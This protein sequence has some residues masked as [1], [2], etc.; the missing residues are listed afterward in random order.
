MKYRSHQQRASKKSES[1]L[2]RVFNDWIV[3]RLGDDFGIDFDVRV[4]EYM[5]DMKKQKVETFAFFLQLKS[6]NDKC[7]G[8]YS[9]KLSMSDLIFFYEQSLPVV[10]IKYYEKCDSFYYEI[11]QTYVWDILNEEDPNWRLKKYK[12][13]PLTKKF[14][15]L[16]VLK[17]EL[18]ETSKRIA[19]NT[20]F[21]MRLGD[22]IKF[23]ES[24]KH[25]QKYLLEYKSLSMNVAFDA[26]KNG[27]FENAIST[28]EEIAN[29]PNTDE[30]K[31]NAILNIIQQLNPKNPNNHYK[32]IKL[33]NEGEELA[34]RLNAYNFVHI[35]RI[36]R[37]R[38]YLIINI[39]KLSQL[40]YSRKVNADNK[41]SF[42]SFYQI[43]IQSNIQN[44][45]KNRQDITTNINK[46]LVDIINSK[47]REAY[48]I[49]LLEI[50]DAIT[51]QII[52]FGQSNKEFIDKEEELRSPIADELTRML[53][54]CD[55]DDLLQFGY[56]LL[57]QYYYYIKKPGRALDYI[58]RAIDLL[59]KLG[60]TSYLK[61]YENFLNRIK[62]V[63]DPHIN[64]TINPDKTTLGELKQYYTMQLNSL[65]IYINHPDQITR[66]YIIPALNDIDPTN[67]LKY[68][69]YLRVDYLFMSPLGKSIGL[70]SLGPKV[71]WCLHSGG[72][73]GLRF[74]LL[75]DSFVSTYCNNCKIKQ[76]RDDG[77]SCTMTDLFKISNDKEFLAFKESIKKQYK[78]KIL[79]VDINRSVKSAILR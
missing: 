19:R 36:L 33:S 67:Y 31:L 74:D 57:S 65:G 21:N 7:K 37:E 24:Q 43:F 14:E 76:K 61:D 35:F 52:S 54:I 77:W 56:Y 13:I 39:I 38:T 50:I 72:I 1:E 40:F 48:T 71:I 60:Y 29:A 58:N 6:N 25:R 28:F 17:N 26:V 9:E 11:I 69:K 64:I 47:D 46:I 32:I 68:C 49:A 62:T 42:G 55:N 2:L 8:T 53:N 27:E 63:P 12:T 20:V 23:S 16:T 73:S 41:D 70:F 3:N 59:K 4:C 44:E 79:P 34:K 18:I 22:G 30:F 78:T 5:D 10:L 15:N 75:F 45:L 51:F 66:D